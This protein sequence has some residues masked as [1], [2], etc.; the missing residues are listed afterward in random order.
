MI[1]WMLQLLLAY[2]VVSQWQS[3]SEWACLVARSNSG[4]FQI[5]CTK[6]VTPVVQ[7]WKCIEHKQTNKCYRR[8]NKPL[9][10]CIYFDDHLCNIGIYVPYVCI[11]NLPQWMWR[12]SH[13]VN[14][15][16]YFRLKH[17][18]LYFP[19]S[20]HLNDVIASAYF[21]TS[22]STPESPHKHL[23]MLFDGASIDVQEER[24]SWQCIARTKSSCSG[25]HRSQSSKRVLSVAPALLSTRDDD[26]PEWLL[27]MWTRQN[28]FLPWYLKEKAVFYFFIYYYCNKKLYIYAHFCS[29]IVPC[30]IFV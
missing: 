24:T 7:T 23:V 28:N 17:Y 6:C 9:A 8:R 2:N 22:S 25:L 21:R 19:F 30:G 13:T 16:D 4:Q 20:Q 5:V 29:Q 26:C 11:H 14:I 18:S 3:A 10:G 12:W 15:M 1:H 27:G